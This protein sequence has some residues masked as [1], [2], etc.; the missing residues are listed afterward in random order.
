MRSSIGSRSRI[1]GPRRCCL[2]LLDK[3]LLARR[4]SVPGIGGGRAWPS[5]RRRPPIRC[6]ALPAG[7]AC[8]SGGDRRR[9]LQ[10]RRRSRSRGTHRLD[11]GD[12]CRLVVRLRAAGPTRARGDCCPADTASRFWRGHRS[13]GS[14]AAPRRP[15]DRRTGC[16]AG[17]A[18]P[19]VA[20][21]HLA[22]S[23][24]RRRSPP[25]PARVARR[26]PPRETRR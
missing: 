1:V 21:R 7:T 4:S 13:R 26:T 19:P 23:R 15:T 10:R 2:Q 12:A 14:P 16:S 8:R 20:R 17:T 18:L 24:R 9:P 22:G 25:S 3:R 11:A 5:R 6:R